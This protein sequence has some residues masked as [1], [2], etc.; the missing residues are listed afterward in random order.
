VVSYI[1]FPPLLLLLIF[2][3]AGAIGDFLVVWKVGSYPPDAFV[4][5]LGDGFEVHTK[6]PVSDDR[7]G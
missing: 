7:A 6:D 3:A 4:L 2:N 1:W 5:D